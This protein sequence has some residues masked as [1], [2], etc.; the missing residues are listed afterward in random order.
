M[1]LGRFNDLF[2]KRRKFSKLVSLASLGV[3]TSGSMVLS[4]CGSDKGEKKTTDKGE[5]EKG[6]GLSLS[7]AEAKNLVRHSYAYVALFNTL[8]NFALNPKN[9]FYTGGWNRTYVPKALTDHTVTAIAGPNNDTFYV[10]TALDLRKEPVVISYP[11][12]DSKFV[13]LETS[14]FDHYCGLPLSTTKG[15][16][17]KPTAILFYTKHTENYKG[18]PVAGTMPFEMS[19]DYATAFLRVMP[20]SNEPKR[21]EFNMGKMNEIKV[22]T[23]SE[24]SGKTAIPTTVETFPAFGRDEKTFEDNFPEVMQF[25]VNHTVFDPKDEMDIGLLAALKPLGIEPGKTYDPS[26][27][28]KVD[29]KL[30]A[31]TAA[32]VAKEGK[33]RAN[34]FALDKFKPKGE[35]T[36]DAMVS[37]SVT[38][39]VGQP[40]SQAIY[41]QVDA[42]DGQP[43]NALHDYVVRMTKEQLP[44]ATAFWSL[45]LYDGVKF[46]FIPNDSKK[47]SVGENAGMKLNAKGGI[48]I[49]ISAEKP[50]GVPNENWLPINR[51]DLP[52]NPRLR[53]YAPDLAA[54]K[55]WQTPRAEKI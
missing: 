47:Y 3:V 8:A 14:S 2:M 23:L 37:Q 22:Q 44:P 39:P 38:G 7:D 13:S 32:E 16:F 20:H 45:T 53:V 43:M 50:K 35:M 52:L 4:S 1:S 31:A 49:Y 24:F 42:A 46:L 6:D 12:F 15:D 10:I 5:A 11:A 26:V 21:M 25:A 51:E 28:A 48:E 29:G 41:L 33:A 9:P 30:L 17:K 19:G 36:L 34:E 40:A 54:M 27:G 55:T 18:E